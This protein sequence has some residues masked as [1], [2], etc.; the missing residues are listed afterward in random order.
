[1]TATNLYSHSHKLLAEKS[2]SERNTKLLTLQ[3]FGAINN[4]FLYEQCVGP[5]VVKTAIMIS[6]AHRASGL[7]QNQMAKIFC[8]Y[9]EC[10]TLKNSASRFGGRVQWVMDV[11]YLWPADGRGRRSVAVWR[12]ILKRTVDMSGWSC[13][14]ECVEL[15][16]RC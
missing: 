5:S 3:R 12:Q 4:S 9:N 14:E 2:S 1:M 6:Y 15:Q 8:V 7:S 16:Q 10:V 11:T 13:V